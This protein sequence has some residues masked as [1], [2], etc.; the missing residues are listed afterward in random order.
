MEARCLPF[1]SIPHTTRLFADYTGDFARVKDFYPTSPQDRTG[2]RQRASS[3]SYPPQLRAAVADV[4]ERQNQQ[5]GSSAETMK[6]INRLRSGSSAMVTGQQVVLLGGPAFAIYK[7]LTVVKWAKQFTEAGADC[8]PI[9]WLATEDHDFAEV[10][11]CVL[12]T[13][14][15][16][17]YPVTISSTAPEGT[18]V[19]RIVI[20]EPGA[21]AISEAAKLLP[22]SPYRDWLVECYQPQ[23]TLGSAF[24]KLFARVFAENGAHHGLILLDPADAVLHQLSAPVYRDAIVRCAEIVDALEERDHA[25]ERAGY[26]DQV[27]VTSS[28]APLFADQDG[29]RTPIRRDGHEFVIG[30]ERCSIQQLDACIA[31]H[32]G[33]FSP[34]VLLRP[35]IQDF[36]LPTVAYFGGPAEVAYFAQVAVVYEKLLGRVTPI[37]PRFSA[38]LID[39]RTQRHLQ[40]YKISPQECFTRE[41]ELRE[42]LA[43]KALPAEI[44]TVFSQSEKELNVLVERVTETVTRID[45]T[46]REAAEHSGSKMR[47]QLQQLVGRATRAQ[48]MR[49]AEVTRHANV[50][51][52]TLYP[53]QKLQEREIAGISFLAQFGAE[54]LSRIYDQMDL[55][56]TGHCFLPM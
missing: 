52:S 40:H 48:A 56:C 33:R 14:D 38:T 50:L 4:L 30:E 32:P 23:E 27:R 47:H 16:T 53:N 45:G 5:F 21:A 24:G 31:Q 43:A 39:A 7:A 3:L 26:H 25:L 42:L 17:L 37:V 36:L 55:S 15:G 44:E 22:E 35:V 18:P 34:N 41:Q 12:R 54:A 29:I 19:G 20:G 28:T 51:A 49:N 8:V 11:H 9:F 1:S 10:A 6:N 2:L 13:A 46:L